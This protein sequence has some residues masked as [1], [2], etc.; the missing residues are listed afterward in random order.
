MTAPIEPLSISILGIMY[1]G[2]VVFSISGALCAAR[3]RMDILGFILIGTITGIG[4]GTLRDL[5]LGRTV[6]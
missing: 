1:L 6:W 2:D 4:G 5:I 3:H